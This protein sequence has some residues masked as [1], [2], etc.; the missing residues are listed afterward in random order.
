MASDFE[1]TVTVREMHQGKFAQIVEAAGHVLIADEP[2]DVG[3]N[4][5]GPRPY[6]YLAAAL[7]ACTSMT[8]RLYAEH[9]KLPLSD[10]SVAVRHER[11]HAEDCEDCDIPPGTKIDRLTRVITLK[12]ALD[13]AQRAKLLEIADKCPVHKTLKGPIDIRTE[14]TD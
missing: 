1:G 4:N 8:I 14:L 11:I 5:L 2:K 3:G 6:D 13:A 9:K 12:G 7:G 10:V